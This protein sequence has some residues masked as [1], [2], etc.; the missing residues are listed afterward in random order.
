MRGVSWGKF[1]VGGGFDLPF[2]VKKGGGGEGKER[3]GDYPKMRCIEDEFS[4]FNNIQLLL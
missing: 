3:R 4:L 1:N 2:W